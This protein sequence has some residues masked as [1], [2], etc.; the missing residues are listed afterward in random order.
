MK[1]IITLFLLAVVLISG[2]ANVK[3]ETSDNV[4]AD[5]IS[6][7]GED[8]VVEDKEEVKV[9]E[10]MVKKAI[11]TKLMMDKYKYISGGTDFD[12]SSQY[13][14]QSPK[15]GFKAT[16]DSDRQVEASIMAERDCL[17]RDKGQEGYEVIE[18]KQGLSITFESDEVSEEKKSLCVYL[19]A[20]EVG[21]ISSRLV[22]EELSF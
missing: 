15:K 17:L 22:I 7:V 3:T 12:T 4:V 20:L 9:E 10:E 18:T 6:N 13:F 11:E 16:I 21:Q 5:Q 19:K 2:C 1:A 8:N 14:V